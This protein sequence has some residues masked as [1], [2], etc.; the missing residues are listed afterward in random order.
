MR[1]PLTLDLHLADFSYP[2]VSSD[3]L[4]DK[5]I[6]IAR[7]IEDAGFSSISLMDHMHQISAIGAPS[8]PMFDGCTMLAAIAA[9]TEKLSLGLLVGSVTY[10]NPALA[11]KITSTIDI[12][13]HGRAWHGLG[14]G[15]YEEEHRAYG[16][17]MPPLKERFEM[18]EEA[19]QISRTMFTKP[20]ASFAGKHFRVDGAYNNPQ[21]IRGDIPI[22]IGGSGERKTLRL[23]AKYGDACNMFGGPA[24]LAH[25]LGVL[26][27]H[28]S[29]VGRDPAEIT[30]TTMLSVL[31]GSTHAEAERKVQKLREGGTAEAML[32]R[33]IVGDPDTVGE[34][35]QAFKDHGIEGLA[36][37]VPD[38]YDLE[39]LDLIGRTL[40]PIFAR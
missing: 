25:L 16:Y 5:V 34:R 12:I 27:Q 18:L 38:T 37:S 17:R 3:Q 2:G 8:S 1:H 24:E 9:R 4:F 23:V 28:C 7:T 6:S 20:Q 31:I 29:E 35:V 26:E 11:A 22:M 13:S 30:K 39:G 15:W 40:A 19:L 10:R 32:S 36:V 33:F 14:A 21:P